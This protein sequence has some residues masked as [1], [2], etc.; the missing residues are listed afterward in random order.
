MTWTAVLPNL[1]RIAISKIV[2]IWL[3]MTPTEGAVEQSLLDASGGSVFII[4]PS[5]HFRD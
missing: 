3:S 5:R 4:G 1:H 2:G